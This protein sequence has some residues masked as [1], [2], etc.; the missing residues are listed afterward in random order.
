MTSTPLK[1]NSSGI[2][3]Q[4]PIR[5]QRSKPAK[6]EIILGETMKQE[7]IQQFKRT[8]GIQA[9]SRQNVSGTDHNNSS[10]A[11]A[12][13]TF[14]PQTKQRS[15]TGVGAPRLATAARARDNKT[16]V[17]EQRA[18][19]SHVQQ[20]QTQIQKK[21]SLRKDIST[22]KD[23]NS[24]DERAIRDA[25]MLTTQK[26]FF[27]GKFNKEIERI[28]K[29]PT[30]QQ[31]LSQPQNKKIDPRILRPYSRQQSSPVKG[32]QPMILPSNPSMTSLHHNL[33]TKSMS[34]FST[35]TTA[36]RT[37][38]RSRQERSQGALSTN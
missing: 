1:R 11:S 15:F 12:K 29:M 38:R 32:F 21:T 22:G 3:K 37:K 36:M 25:M 9:I 7:I 16:P 2:F 23:G 31:F 10:A 34:C 30:N 8:A 5:N 6:E 4:T 17:Q 33:D 13:K 24:E 18:F 35:S 19:G 27:P 28:T 14:A 26:L 20:S